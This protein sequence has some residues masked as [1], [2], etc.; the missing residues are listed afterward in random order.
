MSG[1]KPPA[2]LL[3]RTKLLLSLHYQ[4]SRLLSIVPALASLVRAGANAFRQLLACIEKHR[5]SIRHIQGSPHRDTHSDIAG[6]WLIAALK[7]IQL[8]YCR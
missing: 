2:N 7:L 3:V 1:Q 4:V 8:H 5:K 6:I